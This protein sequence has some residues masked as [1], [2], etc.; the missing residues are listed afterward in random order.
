MAPR[1]ANVTRRPQ[2]KVVDKPTAVTREIKDVRVADGKA[3]PKNPR[4]WYDPEGI[5]AL[6]ANIAKHGLRNPIAIRT[7]EDGTYTVH[8]GNRRYLAARLLG[9]ETIPAIEIGDEGDEIVAMFTDNLSE[10]IRVMDALA[11]AMYCQEQDMSKDEIAV[12][13][14]YGTNTQ[15]VDFLLSVR[16]APASVQHALNTGKL[17]LS[18]YQNFPRAASAEV[19]ERVLEEAGDRPTVARVKAATRKVREEGLAA[20]RIERPTDPG[21]LLRRLGELKL[22]II[23]ID[24]AIRKTAGMPR[25]QL[26]EARAALAE[27]VCGERGA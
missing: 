10:P 23:E 5:T 3:H 1:H 18:A 17:T 25:L 22:E 27:V 8:H 14:G 19:Q 2:L 12:I 11:V 21:V 20:A 24:A 26:D 4:Q 6:A 13:L 15:K 7:S 9:W 16:T